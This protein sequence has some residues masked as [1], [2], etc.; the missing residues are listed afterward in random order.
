MRRIRVLAVDDDECILEAV[1]RALERHDYDVLCTT[2]LDEARSMMASFQPNLLI[3]DIMLP[4]AMSGLD[5]CREIRKTE[6]IPVI[7]LTGLD[8]NVDRIVG[9]EIG[10]DEYITKP[11]HGGV[12]LAHV[13]AVLRRALLDEPPKPTENVLSHGPLRLE[14][15]SHLVFVGDAQISL[16]NKEFLLLKTLLR[17]ANRVHSLDDLMHAVW[18]WETFVAERTIRSHMGNLRQKLLDEGHDPIETVR[19]VGYRILKRD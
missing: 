3:L 7:F 16:T 11:F 15:D 5:F 18:G 14:L 19:S 10:A 1:V 17:Q 9:L 6:S 2:N 4:G 13:R 12:L 8:D